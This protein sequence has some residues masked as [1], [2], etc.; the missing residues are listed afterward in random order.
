MLADVSNHGCGKI[1][2]RMRSSKPDDA[3]NNVSG[4]HRYALRGRSRMAFLLVPSTS[5]LCVVMSGSS[6]NAW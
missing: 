4:V 2:E 3:L 6:F 5:T 1:A